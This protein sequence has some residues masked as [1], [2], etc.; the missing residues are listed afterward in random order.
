[1]V[2]GFEGNDGLGQ[3]RKQRLQ[4]S[5]KV[6]DF[7]GG[8]CFHNGRT[9]RNS[10]SQIHD[11]IRDD[12]R[13]ADHIIGL[14]LDGLV[15]KML[16][17][18]PDTRLTARQLNYEAE[19]AIKKAKSSLTRSPTS[20]VTD[21][22]PESFRPPSGQSHYSRQS[23]QDRNSDGPAKQASAALYSNEFTHSPRET[24][25]GD[26]QF[27]K[28]GGVTPDRASYGRE[29]KPLRPSRRDPSHF[30]DGIPNQASSVYRKDTE[31]PR[32]AT[33]KVSISETHE[34][35]P[36]TFIPYRQQ[37]TKYQ[38]PSPDLSYRAQS[39]ST[40]SPGHRR[41]ASIQSTDSD[42][43]DHVDSH[44]ASPQQRSISRDEAFARALQAE[45]D[46]KE[47]ESGRTPEQHPAR[48][49]SKRR[50]AAKEVA[51]AAAKVTANPTSGGPIYREPPPEL[52]VFS[53]RSDMASP[54][55]NEDPN[56][57]QN[58]I[59][60]EQKQKMPTCSVD[61]VWAWYKE[62]K[63]GTNRKAKLP[64]HE[65]LGELEGRDQVS[66]PRSRNVT[67]TANDAKTSQVFFVDDSKT[68]RPHWKLVTELALLL[69]YIVKE[70][71]KDG[72]DLFFLSSSKCIKCKTSNDMREAI[73][74]HTPNAT[75]NIN[76]RLGDDL[77]AYARKFDQPA[78]SSSR[79]FLRLG[80]SSS[81]GLKKRSIYIL[82]D[83]IL[84]G[85]D[86]E[87]GKEQIR[88][89]V[90]KILGHGMFRGQLGIQLISFGD[91][92]EG[93]ARL[94]KLD[95]LNQEMGLGVYVIAHEEI[96]GAS[97]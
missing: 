55:R 44:S 79:S 64:Y 57:A 85:D 62:R 6:D 90:E 11:R 71:D 97:Y 41:N 22:S 94:E 43:L 75:T 68:M 48:K 58:P 96:A 25:I 19:Q 15:P 47:F 76:S 9:I 78:P 20:N 59:V 29:K 1:M 45:E 92:K 28:Y 84:A 72:L 16:R 5:D 30:E 46:A 87:Q 52:S 61:Q 13:R 14:V 38:P 33:N 31:R 89:I 7:R 91:D 12:I 70:T 67:L 82:T 10:V 3:Y 63:G 50:V 74:K 18:Q 32:R 93:L 35:E 27:A 24:L 2:S 26:D 53:K 36:S 73:V 95:R 40:Y 77:T 51:E 88:M 65:L 23:R 21:S 49:V 86:S 69:A 17:E 37:S 66:L 39:S 83:G 80:L 4:D 81:E 8:N 34:Y 42:S 60:V 56:H 54:P